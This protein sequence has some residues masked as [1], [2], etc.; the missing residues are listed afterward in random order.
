MAS[1]QPSS[2]SSSQGNMTCKQEAP[3]KYLPP[4]LRHCGFFKGTDLNVGAESDTLAALSLF[5]T[6]SVSPAR[7]NTRKAAPS[8]SHTVGYWRSH[9]TGSDGNHVNL[10]AICNTLAGPFSSA[11]SPDATK[12]QLLHS[13]LQLL[14]E[15]VQTMMICNLK[16][17]SIPLQAYIS[18]PRALCY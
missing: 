17:N 5:A 7:I 9:A 4:H 12:T 3:R 13:Q 16:H 8:S 15:E 1:K 6:P 18:L 10:G 11:I 2:S 14:G